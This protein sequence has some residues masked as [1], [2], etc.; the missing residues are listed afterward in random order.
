[1]GRNES[2]EIGPDVAIGGDAITTAVD[3]HLTG[4]LTAGAHHL[5]G[6]DAGGVARCIGSNARFEL[7]RTTVPDRSP[8]PTS[9]PVSGTATFDHVFAGAVASTTFATSGTTVYAWGDNFHGVAAADLGTGVRPS[10]QRVPVLD[11]ATEIS[12]GGAAACALVGGTIA[13]WGANTLDQLGRG[14]VAVVEDPMP[15][16]LCFDLP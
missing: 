16:S 12:V 15:V 9:A 3:P 5:C 11:G 1:V 14:N 8:S 4:V 6:L 10:P 13:C 7:G 2:G